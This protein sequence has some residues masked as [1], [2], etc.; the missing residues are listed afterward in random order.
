MRQPPNEMANTR[1]QYAGTGC[2]RMNAM[3]DDMM[4]SFGGSAFE[5]CRSPTA[6]TRAPR[7]PK[8]ADDHGHHQPQRGSQRGWPGEWPSGDGCIKAS[9]A[10]L[11]CR[12]LRISLTFFM[13]TGRRRCRH[14]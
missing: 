5:L 14:A 11:A 8:D 3:I 12:Y 1:T 10:E 13:L 6:R 2:L 4:L 9:G 7:V